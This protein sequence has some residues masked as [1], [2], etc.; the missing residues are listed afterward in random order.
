MAVMGLYE[1]LP[2]P[3]TEVARQAR[4]DFE[5]EYERQISNIRESITLSILVAGPGTSGTVAAS[6]RTQIFDQLTKLGHRTF[7]TDDLSSGESPLPERIR[8]YVRAGLVDSVIVLL[9]DAPGF[10][11]EDEEHLEYL[12]QSAR[13]LLLAPL[14]F[15]S[16]YSALPSVRELDDAHGCVYWFAE[17]ELADG[18]VITKAVARVEALRRIRYRLIAPPAERDEPSHRVA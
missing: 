13:C 10:Q 6:Q 1:G 3:K 12:H 9:A 11:A 4:Y 7:Y 5:R 15:K 17:E 8:E 16:E 2:E 14:E 18:A